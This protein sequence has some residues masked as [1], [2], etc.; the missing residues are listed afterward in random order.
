VGAAGL[1]HPVRTRSRP[2]PPIDEITA[3]LA[4]MVALLE[5]SSAN[6]VAID[7]TSLTAR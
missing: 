2:D 3:A 5:W 1:V 4:D 6:L 7:E